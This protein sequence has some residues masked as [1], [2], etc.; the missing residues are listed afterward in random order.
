MTKNIIKVLLSNICIAFVGI[1][2]SF[3]FPKIMSINDY[4]N[5]QAF[6]LYL[7]YL[8]ICQIGMATGM[9]IN[10]VGKNRTDLEKKQFKSEVILLLLILLLFSTLFFC[11][12]RILDDV[13]L[14]YLGIIVVPYCFV[15]SYKSLY[16]AW[17]EFTRYSV[18]NT[19][20]PLVRTFLVL[21]IYFLINV[22]TSET[23]IWIIIGTY[24]VVFFVILLDYFF[25]SRLRCK[26]C[27]PVFSKRNVVTLWL[28]LRILLGNYLDLLFK[29][30]DKLFVNLF[31]DTY[32]FAMYSFAMT[33]HNIMNILAGSISQPMFPY[34]ANHKIERKEM[35]YFKQLLLVFG[36]FTS[37]AYFA[38]T[39]IIQLFIPKYDDSISTMLAYFISFPAA[40]VINCIFINLYK[41]RKETRTYIASL[42][43]LLVLSVGF[44]Y[45]GILIFKSIVG[46]AIATTVVY[47][48]WFIYGCYHFKEV[49]IEKNDVVFLMMYVI[50]FLASA[51]LKNSILGAVLYL[52]MMMVI[53]NICFKNTISRSIYWIK[54]KA[55][56]LSK[57][58][59]R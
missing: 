22:V 42:V 35:Q 48:C 38:C 6:N 43:V 55:E 50:C 36:A 47:Y 10:Y 28:G 53:S 30:C 31:F 12:Y 56:S 5:Y 25:D 57:E 13:K 49:G 32:D 4:S 21:G 44:N 15:E 40:T 41:I 26:G 9:V 14:M 27:N 46:V 18:I 8:G 51:L 39:F 34:M 1:V 33:T 11:L 37:T 2:T 29:T 59:N 7:S 58:K 20:I 52:V 3:V 24:F 17:S 19:L 23:V 54:V 45:M 16:Q